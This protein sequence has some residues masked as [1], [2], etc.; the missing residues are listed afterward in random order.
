MPKIVIVIPCHVLCTHPVGLWISIRAKFLRMSMQTATCCVH[1][2][3][4]IVHVA[5]VARA[6]MHVDSE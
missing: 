6:L 1:S 3:L 4:C 5:L 2:G